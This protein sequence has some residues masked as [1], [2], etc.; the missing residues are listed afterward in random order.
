MNDCSSPEAQA[1]QK[2]FKGRWEPYNG[3][4]GH[5]DAPDYDVPPDPDDVPLPF[6]S[7]QQLA[8]DFAEKASGKL[9]WSPG[10]DWMT[11]HGT[12]WERDILLDRFTVAKNICRH[13]AAA[14]RDKKVKAKIC[15]ASTV[16]AVLTLARSNN[17]IVTAVNEWDA[18]P[19]ILNTPDKAID[20]ET[21]KPVSRDG[22]LFMQTTGVAPLYMPTPVWDKFISEIFDND[23]EMIEFMQRLAGYCLT[24]SIKEQ[25][26][27]FLH[28]GGA[29]GKSVF[30][31]VLRNIS[32]KYSHNLPSEALMT[33][34]NEGHPTMYASLHGKRLAISSEIEESAHWAESRIKSMT[35]DETLTARFMH[36]DFFTFA[37]TH[38]HIVAGNSKPRLKGDDFAMVRR[39]ILIPF[40]QKFEGAR[41][42]NNLPDKLK[43]EYPGILQWAIEG[44]VKWAL[45]GLSIPEEV[46]RASREYMSEN[47]DLD[48]WLADC[49]T[50]RSDAT[51]RSSE[52]YASFQQWKE[53]QGEHP[54]SAKS[55]SQ[56]L[57]R[58]FP[59]KATAHGKV[60]SGL[61]VKFQA[62]SGSSYADASRGN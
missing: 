26:L 55:F 50:Q 31:D 3:D 16:N 8:C 10:L 41:R 2:A 39:M 11:N 18:H 47:N 57:E 24:G 4:D 30:L 51:T 46:L 37:M 17:G 25:K 54:P 35:G 28:G 19:M 13:A 21:G 61:S 29:N 1:V 48:L 43:A 9:R 53:K 20:L 52:A 56:R 44:A 5:P 49:C 40:N 6:G 22:L 58:H 15:A 36:K 34:R 45:S 14:N 60:F 27:F 12:H 32:G 38:K 7:E 42:D 62:S 23:L 59:K 33:S